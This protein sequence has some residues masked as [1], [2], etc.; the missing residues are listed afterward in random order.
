MVFGLTTSGFVL[1]RLSDIK[2]EIEASLRASLGNAINLLSTELLG[3]IVGILS[4][5]EALIWEQMQGIYDSQYPPSAT[6][7]SLDNVAALT[8]IQ[9][10]DATFSTVTATAYGTLG[11]I[12]PQGSIASVSGTPDNRFTTDAEYE[13]AAGTDEVQTITF[14]SAPTSGDFTL[15][16]NGEETASIA[17]NDTNTDV[18]TALN[19]LTALSGVIVTGDFSGG[20]VVTFSGSD[21]QQDQELL[22]VGDNTLD[23]GGAVSITITETTPGVLPNVD[24]AMTAETAGAVTA[25]AGTLTVIESVIAGWDS[26]T[27]AL[28]AA[29]GNN[30]ETDAE[31]RL[32]RLQTLAAPGAGTTEAIRAEILDLDD[33][34]DAIVYQNV[35]DTTDG[36]GRPPHS[37]EA[38][39]L[40]G[41][42]QDIWDAIFAVA[43]AGI[44]QVGTESGTVTDSQGVVQTVRFSRPDEIE[45]YIE[46]D[47]TTDSTFPV[48]GDTT[49]KT[50]IVTYMEENFSIGDD[51]VVFGTVS[52]ASAIGEE[53]GVAGI[54][55]YVIRIGTALNPTLDDNIAIAADEIATFDTSR[56]EVTIL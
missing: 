28:D 50:Q 29:V 55:D 9:R 4:E 6:G 21:G 20:F 46:I 51:V 38:V 5:R 1:K 2:E 34:E 14:S 7:T 16:F 25:Y 45:I 10:L 8:G 24:M 15:I 42:D 18:Q 39:V 26:V 44:Y 13:I 23:D 49:L 35:E 19:A 47:I 52:L 48:A 43:P 27:N 30:V 54:I 32:R 53:G 11:T 33:V 41:A 40:G 17:Y 56:I 3:Q 22:T 31:F 12:I 37:F 36:D